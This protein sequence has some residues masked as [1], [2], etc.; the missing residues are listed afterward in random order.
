M[1][2]RVEEKVGETGAEGLDRNGGLG[3]EVG[4]ERVGVGKEWEGRGREKP[5]L[6]LPN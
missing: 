1:T 3:G 6:R 2:W 5:L 4:E